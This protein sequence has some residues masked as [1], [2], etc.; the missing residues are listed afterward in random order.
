L[1][2]SEGDTIKLE[3]IR[4]CL[5]LGIQCTEFNPGRR[6]VTQYIINRLDETGMGSTSAAAQVCSLMSLN[7]VQNQVP[8]VSIPASKAD[9][10]PKDNSVSPIVPVL[11]D[12]FLCP[13]SLALMKDP[14]MVATGQVPYS[15]FLSVSAELQFRY[16]LTLR[17]P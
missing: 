16:H 3:Q 9:I 7:I 14:V 8:A 4:A 6:P 10:P 12:A 1:Q 13:I 17:I 2:K 11:P 5:E 15:L